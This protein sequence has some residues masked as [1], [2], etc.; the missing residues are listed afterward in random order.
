MFKKLLLLTLLFSTLFGVKPT[1]QSYI[2]DGYVVTQ[3]DLIS[4]VPLIEISVT[5]N[6]VPIDVNSL[7]LI[8]DATLISSANYAYSTAA[9]IFKLTS[10]IGPLG[11]GAHTFT[12]S[13][14]NTDGTELVVV[15]FNVA[16]DKVE[17]ID[18][19]IAYP[20]PA[21]NDVKITYTLT[22][23]TDLDLYIYDL[24]GRLLYKENMP[25]GSSGAHAGYNEVFYDLTDPY[26]NPIPNGVYLV[27]VVDKSRSNSQGKIGKTKFFV[28]RE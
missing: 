25:A 5:D 16:L 21:T 1:V 20:S 17:L 23:S 13:A 14:Q 4:N 11:P 6:G 18:K 26:N 19:P 8:V 3:G 27:F 9:E 7:Q 22:Q 2:F 24:S 12:F 28:L 15:T 10:R